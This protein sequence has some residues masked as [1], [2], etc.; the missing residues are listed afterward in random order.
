[1]AS[2]TTLP[3][4]ILLPLL[5]YMGRSQVRKLSKCNKR[6]NAIL[7]PIINRSFTCKQV[8][9]LQMY[10]GFQKGDSAAPLIKEVSFR[11]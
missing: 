1:M 10:K 5:S 3:V 4:E 8:N 6:L 9:I 11:F 7:K 2:I